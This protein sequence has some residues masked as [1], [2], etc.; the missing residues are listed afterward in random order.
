MADD[1]CVQASG[2]V[3]PPL[4]GVEIRLVD[5]PDVRTYSLSARKLELILIFFSDSANRW[6]ISL[7]INLFLEENYI[8]EVMMVIPG[9]KYSPFVVRRV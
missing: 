1:H 6:D 9:C 8:L 3:G 5:V 2:S 4:P 7:L